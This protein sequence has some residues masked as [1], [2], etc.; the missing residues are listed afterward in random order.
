VKDA[1]DRTV[2][3]SG[4]LDDKNY[5]DPDAHYFRSFPI[6]EEGNIIYRHNLWDMVG[7][8]YVRVIF[9]DY[10]EQATYKVELAEDIEGPLKVTA[11]LR[12]RKFHQ[13]IV[14]V[15]TADSGITF[16]ITDLS[17]STGVVD[18]VRDLAKETRD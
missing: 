16:P 15:A 2:F 12:M 8:T 18:V 6:D 11:R 7:T 14:D 3:H 4:W 10:S 13:K 9:P 1:T 5:I 17:E